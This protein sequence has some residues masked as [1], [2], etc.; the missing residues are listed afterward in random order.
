MGARGSIGALVPGDW[1]L[2]LAE[3]ADE[4]RIM[5]SLDLG[6]CVVTPCLARTVPERRM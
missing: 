4:V 6:S 3:N 5:G 1:T 2:G